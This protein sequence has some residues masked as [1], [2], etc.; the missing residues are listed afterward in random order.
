MPKATAS[1]P[2]ALYLRR[3]GRTPLLSRDEVLT[4]SREVQAWLTDENPSPSV[5]ATGQGAKRKI[6][7]ANLRLVVAIARKYRSP[8][9]EF[10]DLIQEGNIGLAHA[11]EKFDYKKGYTFST[12]AYW[13]IRQAI[14]RAI[15]A[16]R[17]I[18][19]PQH[20]TEK[21]SRLKSLIRDFDLEHGRSPSMAE[22]STLA[23]GLGLNPAMLPDLLALEGGPLA[24]LDAPGGGGDDR[25]GDLIAAPSDDALERLGD[26]QQLAAIVAQAELSPIE[27]RLVQ[28]RVVTGA[29]FP[30]IAPTLGLSI[31]AAK[32]IHKKAIYKLKRAAAA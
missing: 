26:Q 12:Y 24:S 11:V 10:L 17:T 20:V 15:A 21:L 5:V 9:L 31:P 6:I 23:Q 27:L 25:L 7:E 29:S 4:L 32:K 13:W 28:L 16:S 2:V 3:I 30:A 8:G 1:D 18:R 14:G 22:T 19:L